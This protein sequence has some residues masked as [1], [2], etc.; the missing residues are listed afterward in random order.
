MND[1]LNRM[2]PALLIPLMAILMGCL[3]GMVIGVAKYWSSVR[4]T[5]MEAAL[6][7]DMLNRGMSAME[8]KQVLEAS[9]IKSVLEADPLTP[10]DKVEMRRMELQAYLKKQMLENGMPAD[11]IE[12]V[13]KAGV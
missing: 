13:L 3:T 6:K 8:I 5:E 9:T 10:A 11:Q 7:Q 1:L 4:R 2:D 12:K